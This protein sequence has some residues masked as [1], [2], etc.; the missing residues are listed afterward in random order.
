MTLAWEEEVLGQVEER[1]WVRLQALALD[2]LIE[3]GKWR[4]VDPPLRTQPH[5]RRKRRR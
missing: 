1:L 4:S 3:E 5:E 2:A